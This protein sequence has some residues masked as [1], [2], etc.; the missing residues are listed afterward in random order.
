MSL[1]DM[2]IG[3]RLGLGFGVMIALLV[4]LAFV[5]VANLK[6][7]SKGIDHIVRV[8]NI[9]A[10]SAHVSAR[11]ILAIDRSLITMI[12]AEDSNVKAE[13]KQAI[14]KSRGI[15]TEA[16]NNI[17]RLDQTEKGKTLLSRIKEMISNAREINNRIMALTPQGNG[18]RRSSFI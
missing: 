10:D 16:V 3:T 17:E 8:G 4:A 11:E 9:L 18:Q 5:G 15:Y 7:I 13:E 14:E 1:R 12:S 2:K 6:S